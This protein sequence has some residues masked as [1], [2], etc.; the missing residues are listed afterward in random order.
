[1]IVTELMTIGTKKNFYIE[2]ATDN[3]AT[4][5]KWTSTTE[6]EYTVPAGKRWLVLAGS[7]TRDANE[8]LA[9][10]FKDAS[11]KLILQ[12][13]SEGAATGYCGFFSDGANTL[14]RHKFPF[15]LVMDAGEYIHIVAGGAQGAGAKA[16]LVVLEI[17]I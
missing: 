5:A 10:Y 3:G 6:Q 11:D 9:V 4:N 13:I 16:S 15:P 17:D 2:D 1:M 14:M 8:T 7:V 12:L